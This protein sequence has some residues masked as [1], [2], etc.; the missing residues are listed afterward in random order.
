MKRDFIK[1]YEPGVDFL[2]NSAENLLKILE[3]SLDKSDYRSFLHAFKE[4]YKIIGELF[5]LMKYKDILGTV[6][7]DS[8]FAKISKIHKLLA[9]ASELEDRFINAISNKIS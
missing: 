9:E 2:I 4:F 6:T 7:E 1:K 3:K 8:Q 5:A